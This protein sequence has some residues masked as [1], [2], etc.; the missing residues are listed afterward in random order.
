MPVSLTDVKLR[1]TSALCERSLAM[2]PPGVQDTQTACTNA[3][4]HS[5]PAK[6]R[7]LQN[8]RGNHTGFINFPGLQS[9]SFR[10]PWHCMFHSHGLRSRLGSSH[11]QSSG[12]SRLGVP[13]LLLGATSCASVA[14][15]SNLYNSWGPLTTGSPLWDS[16]LR[17]GVSHCSSTLPAARLSVLPSAASGT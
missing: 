16:T 6:R 9:T 11:G 1:R 5:R 2:K 3:C 17:R 14:L 13:L 15:L 8:G 4:D 12:G 7:P 10:H